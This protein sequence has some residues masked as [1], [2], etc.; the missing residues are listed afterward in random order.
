MRAERRKQI[1]LAGLAV[2][3]A[4]AVYRAWSV[5]SIALPTKSTAPTRAAAKPNRPAAAVSSPNVHLEA[6]EAER[7]RPVEEARNL[8]RFRPRPPPL[9][10]PASRA[11]TSG[12]APG[13]NRSP[14]P[15][16]PPIALRFIGIVERTEQPKKIAILR[17]QAGHVFY[18]AEGEVIEGRYRVVRIGVESV[19]LMY[20]DGRGRQTIRLSGG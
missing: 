10:S 4:A 17:D 15:G 12:P 19:E 18:G 9:P 3:L 5:A 2:V 1:L 8:F 13:T 16:P 6:L 11:A 20:V 14:S 7:P